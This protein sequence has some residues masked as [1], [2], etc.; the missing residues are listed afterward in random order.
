MD[1][2]YEKQDLIE[3]YHHGILG[4][5]WGRRRYQNEDGTLTEA[6]KKRYARD[7]KENNA[8][9][10]DNR[11]KDLEK[12]PP[13][14]ERW[15]REDTQRLKTVADESQGVIRTGKAVEQYT[16]RRASEKRVQ[17][18]RLDLSH[19]SDAELRELINRELLERQYNS[20]FNAPPP[21]QVSKGREFARNA[22]EVGGI[23]LGATSTALSIALAIKTLSGK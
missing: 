10:K 14:V 22:L 3:L 20:V 7:I 21:Q 18:K 19:M 11:I 17:P 13:D 16:A 15:V 12:N 6:G 8:K 5:K 9:K 4:Q 2:I 23:A 1:N